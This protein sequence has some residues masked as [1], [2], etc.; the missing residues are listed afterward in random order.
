MLS[1]VEAMVMNKHLIEADYDDT[2]SR[3]LLSIYP[4]SH[5]FRMRNRIFELITNL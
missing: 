3:N 4:R 5:I 2:N 1:N